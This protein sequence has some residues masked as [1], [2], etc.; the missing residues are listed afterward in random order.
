[1][2]WTKWLKGGLFPNPG[3]SF[4]EVSAAERVWF[5]VV[6]CSIPT[7]Y[8]FVFRLMPSWRNTRLMQLRPEDS[9]EERTTIS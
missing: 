3:L 6:L 2:L 9:A 8:L 7:K 4:Q 5:P 1:M